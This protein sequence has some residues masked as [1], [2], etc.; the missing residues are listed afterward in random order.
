MSIKW[1]ISGRQI[2]FKNVNVRYFS[3][4]LQTNPVE[5][6][7]E[8][9]DNNNEKNDQKQMVPSMPSKSF[10]ISSLPKDTKDNF[11]IEFNKKLPTYDQ[12]F[13]YKIQE[14]DFNKKKSFLN[15]LLSTDFK[16]KL[17]KKYELSY[18]EFKQYIRNYIYKEDIR[19]QQYQ[20]KRHG[21]LG[22]DLAAAHFIVSRGGRVRFKRKTGLN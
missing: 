8:N 10:D 20:I 17:T 9:N 2:V 7:K 11:L 5:E 4:K 3:K 12:L 1:M 13:E 19:T 16:A 6:L 22:P 14:K 15:D 21:I 18:D